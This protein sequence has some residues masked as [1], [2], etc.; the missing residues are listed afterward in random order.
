MCVFVRERLY[1][2]INV[3]NTIS[4]RSVLLDILRMQCNDSLQVSQIYY[5]C[6]FRVHCDITL[7]ARLCVHAY[8]C[9]IAKC[10]V[11]YTSKIQ[12]D[13][14]T[15][16]FLL[17]KIKQ[18]IKSALKQLQKQYRCLYSGNSSTIL[19]LAQQKTGHLFPVVSN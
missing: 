18:I 11:I 13:C 7:G 2:A 10:M 19:S 12:T 4:F 6:L 9:I 15:F 14:K 16:T 3:C 8:L 17:K 5:Y 1:S